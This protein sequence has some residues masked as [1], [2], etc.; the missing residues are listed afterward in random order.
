[1]TSL[2]FPFLLYT[3]AAL[4]DF[5]LFFLMFVSSRVW[6]GWWEIRT[7]PSHHS[8]FRREGRVDVTLKSVCPTGPDLRG[9]TGN[10][11]VWQETVNAPARVKKTQDRFLVGV[12]VGGS[13][14][15]LQIFFIKRCYKHTFVHQTS[16]TIHLKSNFHDINIQYIHAVTTEV[17]FAS[18][19]L[20]SPSSSAFCWHLQK[21]WEDHDET[22]PCARL[23][24]SCSLFWNG[25]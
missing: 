9:S 13:G 21:N 24:S 8:R 6:V 3:N 14:F 23:Q 16:G 20:S 17:R 22:S 15:Q 18:T 19:N 10:T 2:S 25:I 5:Y 12:A 11:S 7:K 1:M 4:S